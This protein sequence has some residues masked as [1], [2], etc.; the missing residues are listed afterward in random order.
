LS[1]HFTLAAIAAAILSLAAFAG[2]AAAITPTIGSTPT[3]LSF[4]TYDAGNTGTVGPVATSANLSSGRY[5]VVTE[6]GTW[7]NWG[8]TLWDYG[9]VCGTAT[10]APLWSSPVGVNYKAGI[11]PLFVYAFARQKRYDCTKLTTPKANDKFQFSVSGSTGTYRTWPAVGNPSTPSSDH[12]Y[13][14]FVGSGVNNRPLYFR[15]VDPHSSDNYGEAHLS[16]R[17]AKDSDCGNGGWQ[18]FRDSDNSQSFYSQNN[19]TFN[20]PSS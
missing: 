16:V 5:Y 18:Y 19:C 8:A 10:A 6:Q 17:T 7:S 15:Y 20:L 1:K 14:F 11:D 13:T 12:S 9:K 3:T 2:S 4:D